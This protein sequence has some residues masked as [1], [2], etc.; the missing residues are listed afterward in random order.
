MGSNKYNRGT[1][2]TKIDGST[3]DW[4]QSVSEGGEAG[5]SVF[6]KF[7]HGTMTTTKGSVWEG[8]ALYPWNATATTMT[9]LSD[10]ANDTLLGT[11]AKQ[12]AVTGVDANYDALSET[13]D[14]DGT[15]GVTTSASFL[16]VNRCWV[17]G[18]Q[19]TIGTITIE[20]GGTVYAYIEPE[21]NQ[22][23]MAVYTV[24]NGF[25]G[26]LRYLKTSVGSGKEVSLEL[27]VRNFGGVF[28]V[29]HH[30]HVYQ[31]SYEY[32]F[33]APEAVPGKSDIDIRGTAAVG[34]VDIGAT[35]DVLL[36]AD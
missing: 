26:Y 8:G 14:M 20:N 34:S 15:G 11:G 1:S 30:M 32:R 5:Y 24:P 21:H 36:V 12:V 17:V 35:F 9:V 4:Y 18:D 29:K 27:L 19:D 33:V 2:L 28:R 10:D 23:L 3:K 31:N 6:N 25:T 16:R 22:T 7:G 13:V